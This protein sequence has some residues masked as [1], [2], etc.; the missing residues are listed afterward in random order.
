V[1]DIFKKCKFF[2]VKNHMANAEGGLGI[3]LSNSAAFTSVYQPATGVSWFEAA[4]F[5]NWLNAS[6]GYQVAYN[7]DSKGN[8]RL[9]S[10]NEAWQLDGENLFRHQDAHY[11]LPSM[12]EWYK[13]AFYDPVSKTYFKFPTS[14]GS[15][16]KAVVGGIDSSTAVYYRGRGS[17]PADIKNAGGLSP[18]GI[19]GM[20][21]N[22]FEWEETEFDLV[23][24]GIM[25]IRG[26]RGGY[27]SNNSSSDLSSSHRLG[28]SPVTNNPNIGF[29]VASLSLPAVVVPEPRHVVAQDKHTVALIEAKSR[30]LNA[31]ADYDTA[32]ASNP[33]IVLA[34]GLPESTVNAKDSRVRSF[35]SRCTDGFCNG[36]RSTG[37]V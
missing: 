28:G 17:S 33:R 2:L 6:Q 15:E 37:F 35:V 36:C 30:F 29:R 27:W 22:V 8:F 5:V 24:D 14:D 1:C 25:S 7:F 20:G 18:F 11:W 12:D 9:W 34:W 21:G 3:T 16:P 26:R 13:A 32:I 23:N 19:M 10:S 31:R 4:K